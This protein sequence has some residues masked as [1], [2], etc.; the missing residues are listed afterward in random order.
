MP[1]EWRSLQGNHLLWPDSQEFGRFPE[2]PEVLR[3]QLREKSRQFPHENV[4]I[5]PPYGMDFTPPRRGSVPYPLGCGSVVPINRWGI[6]LG[7]AACEIREVVSLR[8]PSFLEPGQFC[9]L[10]FGGATTSGP[11]LAQRYNPREW[12]LAIISARP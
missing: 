2:I 3:L 11:M 8:G 1:L 4:H 12:M 7:T 5:D 9:F 6:R 10:G